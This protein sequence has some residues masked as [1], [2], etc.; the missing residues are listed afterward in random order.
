MKFRY[1]LVG[2]GGNTVGTNN[3]ELAHKLRSDYDV[4]DCL[5]GITFWVDGSNDTID[6]IS[7]GETL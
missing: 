7:E 3:T 5:E 1:I 4:V 6:E 2:A